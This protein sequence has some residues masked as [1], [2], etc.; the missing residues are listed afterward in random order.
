MLTEEEAGQVRM[1]LVSHAWNDVVCQRLRQRLK[2][3]ERTLK[4]LPSE[5]PKPY[6][7]LDDGTATAH[8]RGRIEEL[9]WLLTHWDMEIA[10]HEHNRK[11]D[12]LH[13]NGAGANLRGR[14]ER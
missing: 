13:R 3:A 7:G 1:L 8:L 11:V 6:Q 5:R 9:E 14:V 2:Q 12:E 4:Q 10:A